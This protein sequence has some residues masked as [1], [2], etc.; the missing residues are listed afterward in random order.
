MISAGQESSYRLLVVDDNRAIHDDI[1]KVLVADASSSEINAMEA[2]LFGDGPEG[3]QSAAFE[4][5]SAYQ[6]QKGFELVQA[7]MREGRP[8]TVA[9]VDMRMPPGWDGIETIEHMWR[10]DPN[11]QVVICSAYSDYSWSEIVQRLETG[12]RLLILKKPFDNV[13]I[14]QMA[15]ALSWKWTLQREVLRASER[16]YRALYDDNPAMFFTIG[17]EGILLSA[18][19]FGAERLGYSVEELV[20]LP[21]SM[22]HA[23]D[24]RTFIREQLKKCFHAPH[25]VH[26]WASYKMRKDSSL[27]WVRETARVVEGTD[28]KPTILTVCEDITEARNLSEQLAY[29][30]SHDDLTGLDNR[31]EFEQHLQQ[32][33]QTARAERI[34]HALCYL[35]LD[36]FKVINDTCGHVAGDELLRQLG[37]LLMEKVRKTDTLARLGGDEFAVLLENCSAEQA[38]RV[39]N[40]L[41][42]AVEDFRFL[43]EDKSF[44]IAASIGLVPITEA[45]GNMNNVLSMADAACYVAKDNGRNRTHMYHED[46]VE[47]AQ[48]CGEMQWVARINRALEENRFHLRC[49]PIVP[50]GSGENEGDHY[51]LLIRMED[52]DG[53]IVAPGAFLPAAERYNISTRLD[54]WVID[55]AFNWLARQPEHLERLSLCSINLSG[56]SL[57]DD[58]FLIFVIDKFNE[59]QVSPKK[60]CFEITETAAIANL[61]SATHFIRTLKALGCRFA[62]DDFGSGLSSFAYLKNLPVDFLKI[63]GV[64]VK[65]IVDDPVDL[66]IVRSINDMGHVLGKRTIAEFVENAAVLEKLREIGVD[67]AQGYG[68]SS[69]RHQEREGNGTLNRG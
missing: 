10:E 7:A 67:Y 52:E 47:V 31:R 16:R 39:A 65:G 8:Y 64:F 50:I 4:I 32:V 40:K 20:G 53:R 46:D 28:G 43:W 18:N 44:N 35:D 33:L 38:Y 57:G 25:T 5:C 12:D 11:L 14:V 49:Q 34:E 62:L 37:S 48:R 27:L 3:V 36:Q 13:E 63:D 9:F 61:S 45:S 60:I 51:E 22:L 21:V 26:R 29:Q 17:T 1:R 15:H 42:K 23:D 54:H 68:I 55:T 6:G 66:A 41:R 56:H 58:D 59:G 30:A 69:F 24:D 2:K 19:R